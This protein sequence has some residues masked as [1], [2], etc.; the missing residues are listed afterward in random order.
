MQAAELCTVSGG[1]D[2]SAACA[3]AESGR[4]A[5]D[6]W[7][8]KIAAQ[9]GHAVPRW[10]VWALNGAVEKP[11]QHR[12]CLSNKGAYYTDMLLC[13]QSAFQEE[14]NPR[15]SSGNS[16]LQAVWLD[17]RLSAA[18]ELPESTSGALEGCCSPPQ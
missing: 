16:P 2:D 15:V 1:E 7:H 13:L 6:V 9:S 14:G 3:V 12:G 18:P 5:A 17:N 8:R 11:L 4:A 10:I